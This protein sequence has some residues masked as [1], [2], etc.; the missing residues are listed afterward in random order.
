MN[1]KEF[2]QIALEIVK[3]WP[4]SECDRV[5]TF[6]VVS[7]YPSLIQIDFGLERADFDDGYFWSRKFVDSGQAGSFCRTMPAIVVDIDKIDF[8]LNRYQIAVAFLDEVRCKECSDCSK[9]ITDVKM[10]VEKMARMF[11]RRLFDY[12]IV[13]NGGEYSWS[14]SILNRVAATGSMNN[15]LKLVTDT[16]EP[17]HLKDNLYIGQLVY[18]IKASCIDIDTTEFMP[19]EDEDKK[20]TIKCQ[21]CG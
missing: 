3:E 2:N 18:E 7:D 11:N 10:N 13:K 14:T 20:A 15:N 6:A 17:Y 19:Y 12:G 8:L 1:P 5:D 16:F 21:R 9:G 4:Y